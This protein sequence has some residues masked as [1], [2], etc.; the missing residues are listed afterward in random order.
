VITNEVRR[1][2]TEA[3]LGQFDEAIANLEAA[4]VA[5]CCLPRTRHI[6]G[7]GLG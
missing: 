4:P 6:S 1:R 2:S 3:Y 7:S 5:D